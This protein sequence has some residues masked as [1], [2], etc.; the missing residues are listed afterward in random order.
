MHLLFYFLSPRRLFALGKGLVLL[1]KTLMAGSTLTK[2]GIILGCT[3]VGAI[4]VATQVPWLRDFCHEMRY[5]ETEIGRTEGRE[6]EHWKKKKRRRWLSL[7]PF[8]RY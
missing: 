5:I 7:L 2:A 6:Q 1:G 3:V 4:A 8:F